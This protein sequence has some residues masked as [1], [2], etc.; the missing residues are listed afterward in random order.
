MTRH[1]PLAF[2]LAFF[3][4]AQ[5]ASAFDFE[6][7]PI[8]TDGARSLVFAPDGKGVYI[9]DDDGNIRLW[10]LSGGEVSVSVKTVLEK[11][12]FASTNLVRIAP[13]GKHVLMAYGSG[14]IRGDCAVGNFQLLN[15]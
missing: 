13:D 10:D 1:G 14:E 8:P 11:G 2:A 3:L 4:A 12:K 5:P 7:L 15:N 9:G 6:T